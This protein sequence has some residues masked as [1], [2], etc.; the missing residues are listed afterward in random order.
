MKRVFAI[1]TRDMTEKTAVCVFPWEMKLL[2]HIHGQ[3][4]QQTTLDELCS[5]KGAVKVVKIKLPHADHPDIQP[6]EAPGLR[7]QL[8]TMVSVP[9][10]DNPAREPET[11]YGRLAEKYG[12]DKEVNEPVVTRVYGMYSSGHFATVLRQYNRGIDPFKVEEPVEGDKSPSDMTT[13]ELREE[14]TAR[15]IEFKPKDSREQL[16][17][18]LVEAMAAA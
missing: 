10:D 2:E 18:K 17:E 3:D 4:V 8:E 12:A 9:A 13:A 16:E 14:L 15:Q 6:A 7:A 5:I 11:E 1:V